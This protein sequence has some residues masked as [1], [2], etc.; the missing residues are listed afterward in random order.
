MSFLRDL[1]IA[2]RRVAGARA[3]DHC[4]A[5]AGVGDWRECGHFQRVAGGADAAAG[6]SDEI[7]ALYPAERAGIGETNAT[8][9]FEIRTSA[10]AEVD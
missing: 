7:A 9:S 4:C 2:V 3:V 10:V 1:K 8:F 5:D 6:E